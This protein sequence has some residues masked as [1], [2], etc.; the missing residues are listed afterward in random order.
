MAGNPARTPATVL[1]IDDHPLFRKGVLQL[2]QSTENL[3]PV[4]EADNGDA[5]IACAHALAPDLILLDLH[6]KAGKDGIETL[7]ALR[8]QGIESRIVIL[9][10]SDRPGDI[11]AAIRAG[12][13]DYLL[14]DTEP[15][16]L[17]GRAQNILF[18]DDPVSA[19]LTALLTTA[20]REDQA[21]RRRSLDDL[22][23][24]ERLILR[25]LSRGQSNKHI[26]RALDIMES[27]V[28]VHIHSLL[29]KLQFHSR[30]EAAIWAVSI[31]LGKR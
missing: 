12:A 30:V 5:G 8:A 4:G 6:M 10:V 26:A 21:G 9:T 15:E 3:R 31:G 7:Q 22:T 11:I 27:T 18:G 20:L 25:A 13:D 17:L 2:L 14:K 16:A 28:K 29:R 19:E 23:E 24:R 1:V